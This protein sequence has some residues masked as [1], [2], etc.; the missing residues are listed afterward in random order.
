MNHIS[1]Y[2]MPPVHLGPYYRIRIMLKEKMIIS[3]VEN[4]T[5][6]IVYPA[7]RGRKMKKRTIYH[8]GH[9]SETHGSGANG[10]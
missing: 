7:L 10:L 9:L 6:G 1:A 4:K 2:R 5:I 8:L 3:L